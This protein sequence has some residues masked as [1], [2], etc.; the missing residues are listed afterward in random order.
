MQEEMPHRCPHCH[1]LVVDRRSANCTTCRRALP[2]D[3]IMTADQRAKTERIDRESKA[4]HA[5]SMQM[6][7]PAA[8][9]PDLPPIV[10]MLGDI[11]L[12]A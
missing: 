9:N 5:S 11:G 12:P 1:A 8:M 2:V 7:D 6:L 4:Q 3:W 10:R